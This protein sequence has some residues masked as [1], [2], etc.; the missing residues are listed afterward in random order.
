MTAGAPLF[1]NGGKSGTFTLVLVEVEKVERSG[2][3]IHISRPD[4]HLEGSSA[5]Q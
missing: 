2:A 4:N 3:E 5:G 1:C